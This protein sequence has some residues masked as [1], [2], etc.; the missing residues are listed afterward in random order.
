MQALD[1]VEVSQ[2]GISFHVRLT[3]KGGR[4]AVDGWGEAADGNVHLKARVSA[5]PEDGKANAALIALVANILDVAK[6]AVSITSG[7]TARLKRIEVNG[8]AAKLRARL[9]AFGEAI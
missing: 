1:P 3:P 9:M 4:D 7:Q 8:D 5:M 2:S 6:S